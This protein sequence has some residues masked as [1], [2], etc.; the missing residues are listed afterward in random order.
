M[1]GGC[2]DHSKGGELVFS[3]EEL[4]CIVCVCALNNQNAKQSVIMD[5]GPL[6]YPCRVDSYGLCPDGNGAGH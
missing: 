2:P 1:L 3:F 5:Y 4:L 6:G